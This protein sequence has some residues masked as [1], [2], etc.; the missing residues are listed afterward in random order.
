LQNEIGSLLVQ[1]VA[2][3]TMVANVGNQLPAG[4]WLTTFQGQR[5]TAPTPVAGGG[6]PADPA[7]SSPA[8]SATAN[9]AKAGAGTTGAAADPTQT[10]RVGG[11]TAGAAPGAASSALS[12]GLG[13]GTGR[14]LSCA[15]I[16]AATG[17]VAMTGI[18]RDIPA[19]ALFVDQLKKS[20]TDI[21]TIWVSTAQLGKFGESDMIT[22][23]LNAQLG[24][25]A[26]GHRLEQFFKEQPCK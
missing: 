4:V 14:G 5:T 13:V 23:S 3:P 11:A 6:A 8:A 18:A 21:Q 22:F 1:D 9:A 17:T 24:K 10:P 15:A 25:T 26:R 7:A 2:W 19:L 16:S 20:V 12:S